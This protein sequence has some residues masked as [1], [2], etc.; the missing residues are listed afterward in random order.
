MLF[1]PDKSAKLALRITGDRGFSDFFL[2]IYTAI[3]TCVCIYIYVSQGPAD[4]E[5]RGLS[6]LIFFLCSVILNL[7]T[8][9]TGLAGNILP[10]DPLLTPRS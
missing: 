4:L 9:V 8:H 3:V 5:S 2:A 10:G 6:Y 7:R 1:P